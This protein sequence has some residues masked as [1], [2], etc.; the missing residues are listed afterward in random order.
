MNRKYNDLFLRILRTTVSLHLSLFVCCSPPGT[1][2]PDHKSSSKNIAEERNPAGKSF[3]IPGDG[4][5]QEK[6]AEFV[7]KKRLA[8]VRDSGLVTL[9]NVGTGNKSKSFNLSNL[10]GGKGVCSIASSPSGNRLIIG[11]ENNKLIL[12]NVRSEKTSVLIELSGRPLEM[13]IS[14]TGNNLL[15]QNGNL[16]LIYMSFPEIKI[17][18]NYQLM[19]P[20]A[21]NIID[22]GIIHVSV[23]WFRNRIY[24]VGRNEMFYSLGVTNGRLMKEYELDWEQRTHGR[25]VSISPIQL[26]LLLSYAIRE[27]YVFSIKKQ[28]RL[29][30]ISVGFE[31]IKEVEISSDGNLTAVGLKDGTLKFYNLKTN[32]FLLSRNFSR[33]IDQVVFS[34]N[35]SLILIKF[36]DGSLRLE[37]FSDLV[38][39]KNKDIPFNSQRTS[40]ILRSFRYKNYF[41]LKNKFL[42]NPKKAVR[43]IHQILKESIA[44]RKRNRKKIN[45]YLSNLDK[46]SLKKRKQAM[47]KLKIM[48][49]TLPVFIFEKLSNSKL[50]TPEFIRRAEEMK[51][52]L[53]YRYDA[54]LLK[55]LRIIHILTALNTR[56]GRRLLEKVKKKWGDLYEGYEANRLFIHYYKN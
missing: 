33:E 15:V 46:K 42:Q 20:T 7:S 41:H 19:K 12:I 13:K 6:L 28:K 30:K 50:K 5:G 38:A 40:K 34:E 1:T 49:K 37:R 16:E 56:S 21:K 31:K 8:V 23:D 47:K 52:Y 43:I 2:P 36:K 18:W 3:Q 17:L 45:N 11:G 54:L 29:D 53:L 44:R 51:Q 10:L 27:F 55:R 4:V 24:L 35:N 26:K 39:E 32:K 14:N 25:T 9:W 48:C 22:R